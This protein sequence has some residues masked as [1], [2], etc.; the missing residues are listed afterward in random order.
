MPY[1]YDQFNKIGL[2]TMMLQVLTHFWGKDG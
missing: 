1:E 2:T